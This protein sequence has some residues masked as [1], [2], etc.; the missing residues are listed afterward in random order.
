MVKCQ[1]CSKKYKN[2]NGLSKHVWFAHKITS[3][4]Y[5]DMYFLGENEGICKECG[6]K[7]EYL[8]ISSGYR[9]F[10]SL[11]CARNNEEVKKKFE[12]TNLERH[13]FKN[14]FE[15][16]EVQDEIRK[17]NIEN[18]GVKY[19]GQSEEIKERI[20]KTNLENY[21]TENPLS[22]ESCIR[23]E[24][25]E[26]IYNDY[27]V[28]NVFQLDE[29]KKKS[30]ET[31]LK[32]YGVEYISQSSTIREKIEETNLEKFGVKNVS[33]SEEIKNRKRDTFIRLYNVENVNELVK[34]T[35]NKQLQLYKICQK[36]LPYPILEY[37]EGNK[38]I[39]ITVPSLSLAIE[40]DGSYWHQ[41]KE[42]DRIRQKELEEKG[43][44]FI[45]YE[46]KVPTEEELL[47]DV[48]KII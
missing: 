24:M 1:V 37:K 9:D 22:R 38:F 42:R 20:K 47:R 30:K 44:N 29:V 31:N 21:G 16:K 3:K 19:P 25:E 17:T 2:L 45:R 18:Y 6:N 7:T 5:Y 8:R 41:D 27:G 36:V 39:D 40:Y 34:S 26:R 14:P 13:G 10:C 12:Q 4:Q 11:K 23:K 43:W 28:E 48:N 35:S 33:C 46:D 32:K 15:S